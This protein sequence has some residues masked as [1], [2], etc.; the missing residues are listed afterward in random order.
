MEKTS[1]NNIRALIIDDD[2]SARTILKKYL[3]ITGRVEIIGSVPDTSTAM[4]LIRRGRV[5]VVFLDINMPKEDG[6]Q[7]ATRLRE[8]S[9]HVQVV[10]TTAYKDYAIQAFKVKPLDYLVKPFG[11]DEVFSVIELVEGQLVQLKAKNLKN[12]K[13]GNAIH[14]V[15]KLKMGKGLIFVNVDQ[16]VYLKSVNNLTELLLSNGQKQL[17]KT[18]INDVDEQLRKPDFFKINR[19][20]LINMAYISRVDRK[21]RICVIQCNGESYEFPFSLH[22]FKQF[23]SMNLPKL[24]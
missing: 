20:A 14:G 17:V 7:F 5:D 21:E 22:I 4:F 16:I 11:I 9:S 23:E 13:W 2:N 6:L 1:E 15:I 10:F 3:E 8:A 12:E 19:S 18:S 24:G